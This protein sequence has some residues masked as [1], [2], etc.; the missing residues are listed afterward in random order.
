MFGLSGT[1]LSVIASQGHATNG[2]NQLVAA[3][4]VEKTFPTRHHPVAVKGDADGAEHH[5][6]TEIAN[7]NA[8]TLFNHGKT[9]DHAIA[10]IVLLFCSA[11][12]RT[13]T[14]KGVFGPTNHR[15]YTNRGRQCKPTVFQG[16]LIFTNRH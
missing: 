9:S 16:T 14:K 1:A 6:R 3:L 4:S 15:H 8:R 5:A 7:R 11:M 2:S 13:P 10:R 12:A